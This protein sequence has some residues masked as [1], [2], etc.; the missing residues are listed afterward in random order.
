MC[1]IV[2]LV[3]QLKCVDFCFTHDPSPF[4]SV[5]IYK[6]EGVFRAAADKRGIIEIQHSSFNLYYG[7]FKSLTNPRSHTARDLMADKTTP[8]G[9]GVDSAPI[10]RLEKLCMAVTW[11]LFKGFYFEQR[12]ITTRSL[13]AALGLSNAK[14]PEVSLS[15]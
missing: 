15:G 1:K 7:D 9:M 13:W 4:V 3:S 5:Q 11:P 2:S 14:S 10:G 8:R 6:D 12:N